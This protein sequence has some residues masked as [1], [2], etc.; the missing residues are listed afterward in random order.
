MLF[1]KLDK[2][3]QEEFRETINYN[4]QELK[5]LE[6][7]VKQARR[8]CNLDPKESGYFQFLASTINQLKLLLEQPAILKYKAKQK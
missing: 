1:V 3:L 6:D 4:L 7:L 2:K 5:N 8:Y